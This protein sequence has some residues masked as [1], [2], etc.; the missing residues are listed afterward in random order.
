MSQNLLITPMKSFFLLLSIILPALNALAQKAV[1]SKSDSTRVVFSSG[2]SSG[3]QVAPISIGEPFVSSSR[4]GTLGSQQNNVKETPGTVAEVEKS[5]VKFILYP[6]PAN[7]EFKVKFSGNLNGDFSIK[8]YDEIGREILTR[9][10]VN[11]DTT[12][13]IEDFS[14]GKY[15][16][17]LYSNTGEMIFNENLIKL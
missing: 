5:I 8:I 9:Y 10:F 14:P 7:T 1:T 12:I 6:N 4:N 13:N 15:V 2:G 16:V 3:N 11:K 17:L